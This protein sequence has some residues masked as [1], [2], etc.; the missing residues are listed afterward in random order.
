M[1]FE[2]KVSHVQFELQMHSLKLIRS[3]DRILWLLKVIT[4]ETVLS[5]IIKQSRG[6]QSNGVLTLESNPPGT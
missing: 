2:L 4:T 6:K 3:Q 1:L 5:F